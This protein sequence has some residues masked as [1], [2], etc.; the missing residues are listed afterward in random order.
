MENKNV[1]ILAKLKK[2]T[3]ERFN[4]DLPSTD[5][6]DIKYKCIQLLREKVIDT[7]TIRSRIETNSSYGYEVLLQNL[8]NTDEKEI[9]LHV[10]LSTSDNKSIIIFTNENDDLIFGYVSNYR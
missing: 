8:T 9:K 2:I 4:I 1:D 6:S 10:L 5:L 3:R 7:Y